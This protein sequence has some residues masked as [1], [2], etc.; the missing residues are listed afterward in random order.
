MKKFKKF[1][2]VLCAISMILAM[3]VSAFAAETAGTNNQEIEVPDSPEALDTGRIVGV[4]FFAGAEWDNIPLGVQEN[5]KNIKL[6]VYCESGT[7]DVIVVDGNGKQIRE[8]QTLVSGS[9]D[10]DF[11]KH[12]VRDESYTGDYYLQVRGQ[13]G[14]PAS[15]WYHCI[16][17]K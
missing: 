17:A 15:G 10:D 2:S 12:F 6:W 1:V 4:Q 9:E 7:M 14:Y 5:V 11:V 13:N 16:E 8:K 3:S